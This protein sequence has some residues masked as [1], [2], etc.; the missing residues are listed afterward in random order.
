MSSLL[1]FS[2]GSSKSEDFSLTDVEVFVDSKEQNWFKLA[3]VGKFLRIE[4]IRTSG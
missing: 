2:N 1:N 3:H 4:D